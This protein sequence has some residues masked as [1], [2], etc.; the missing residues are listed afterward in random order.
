MIRTRHLRLR[1]NLGINITTI[2][3]PRPQSVFQTADGSWYQYQNCVQSVSYNRTK[4]ATDALCCRDR[5]AGP[6]LLHPNT[7]SLCLVARVCGSCPRTDRQHERLR[8]SRRR[9]WLSAQTYQDRQRVRRPSAEGKI[10]MKSIAVKGGEGS[11]VIHRIRAYA[12]VT[13]IY[14]NGFTCLHPAQARRA[15]RAR[16]PASQMVQA[17]SLSVLG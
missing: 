11:S 9:S 4:L 12:C 14:G 3:K 8:R 5:R 15:E 17:A 1:T 2:P 6:Q 7:R 10:Q 13:S 16:R